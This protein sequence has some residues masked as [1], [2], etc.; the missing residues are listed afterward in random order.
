VKRVVA[1]SLLVA[2]FTGTAWAKDPGPWEPGTGWR[3]LQALGGLAVVVGLV[4]LTR[5]LLVRLGA[6]AGAGSVRLREV[7][8]L[9]P[10]HALYV[11]EVDGRRLLL[12]HQV[13]L[14]CELGPAA[15]EPTGGF[16]DRLRGA[17]RKLRGREGP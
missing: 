5:T 9:S 8:R 1:V 16:A 11:V 3:V 15:S 12:G 14:V 4:V 10:H 6:G 13:G 2:G 7:V 17:T